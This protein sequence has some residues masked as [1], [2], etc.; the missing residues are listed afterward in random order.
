MIPELGYKPLF[1]V[2]S[3]RFQVTYL[4][5]VL[6]MAHDFQCLAERWHMQMYIYLLY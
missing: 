2:F 5:F 3:S 1:S 4:N 6:K